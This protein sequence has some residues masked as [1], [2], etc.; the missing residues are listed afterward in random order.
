MVAQTMDARIVVSNSNVCLDN[1][2]TIGYQDLARAKGIFLKWREKVI[3][4][5]TG[6]N[7]WPRVVNGRQVDVDGPKAWLNRVALGYEM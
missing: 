2:H 7:C 6:I 4:S 5:P 3:H 1:Q